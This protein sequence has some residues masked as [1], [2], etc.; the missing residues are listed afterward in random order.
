MYTQSVCIRTQA[1]FKILLFNQFTTGKSVFW[2]V[3]CATPFFLPLSF[4]T[5]LQVLAGHLKRPSCSKQLRTNLKHDFVFLTGKETVKGLS[6][7][8]VW[9]WKLSSSKIHYEQNRE[10]P[11]NGICPNGTTKDE[12]LSFCG[13]SVWKTWHSQNILILSY[14]QD[15]SSYPLLLHTRR[16]ELIAEEFSFGGGNNCMMIIPH[17]AWD[18]IGDQGCPGTRWGITTCL[19]KSLSFY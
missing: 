7:S 9:Q 1:S 12:R 10:V 14:E 6:L 8:V 18:S 11:G 4:Q 16:E 19:W 17:P 3:D 2:G 5:F 15:Y 13:T